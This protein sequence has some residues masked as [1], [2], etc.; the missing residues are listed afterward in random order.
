MKTTNS[1]SMDAY[2]FHHSIDFLIIRATEKILKAKSLEVPRER[3]YSDF[4][5]DI[6]IINLL[7]KNY[8]TSG[9]ITGTF[10]LYQ[11]SRLEPRS[12][13]YES[14]FA[15]L[16]IT[17]VGNIISGILLETY[18]KNKAKLKNL[19]DDNVL[20]SINSI[21]KF[22]QEKFLRG[23]KEYLKDDFKK[24]SDC[25][26]ARLMLDKQIIDLQSYSALVDSFLYKQDIDDKLKLAFLEFSNN[27][28]LEMD[29]INT[30]KLF[31][32]F[33]GYSRG[34]FLKFLDEEGCEISYFDNIQ[35]ANKIEG[36]PASLGFAKGRILKVSND[37]ELLL[38]QREESV[39]KILCYGGRFSPDYYKVVFEIDGVITWNTGM[40]GH[41]PL[42]CRGLGIPCVIIPNSEK[43]LLINN[44]DVIVSGGQG[45]IY[46]GLY[47]K[48]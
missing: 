43:K 15:V 38:I 4:S 33:E 35:T 16:V 39:K 7:R 23:N 24:I 27:Y 44:D 3:F 20:S 2:T 6:G 14:L 40:T 19:F 30:D 47:V 29:S 18:F 12:H 48:Q 26:I 8:L 10:E 28:L 11:N 21:P 32:V 9:E 34:V 13:R 37:E 1:D 25:Y 17:I 46:T 42:I 41:L 22:I 45:L 36:I 5:S 31:N